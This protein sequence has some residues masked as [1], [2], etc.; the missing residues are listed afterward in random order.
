VIFDWKSFWEYYTRR[1]ITFSIQLKYNSKLVC[2]GFDGK[3]HSG[4]NR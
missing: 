4:K 2:C 1:G 3:V